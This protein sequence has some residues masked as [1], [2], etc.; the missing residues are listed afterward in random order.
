MKQQ[1]HVELSEAERERLKKHIQSKKHSLESKKRAGVLLKLD[2]SGE[3]TPPPVKKIASRVGVSELSVR[4]YRKEYATEGLESALLRKKRSVP[5]VAPKVTGEVEAHIIATCCSEPPE[6][7]AVWTMQM[8]ADKIVLDGVVD[9]I[10]DETVRLV[11]KKQ[12][13]SLT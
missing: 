5:P 2:E 3:R 8:I 13:S 7:K 11:L 10:S 4:R 1:Y 6:G 12:R 9:S